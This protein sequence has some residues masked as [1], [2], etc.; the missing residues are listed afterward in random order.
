[1]K[2]SGNVLELIRNG[3]R[4][5]MRE[6]GWDLVSNCERTHLLATSTWINFWSLSA[7]MSDIDIEDSDED[8]RG[9]SQSNNPDSDIHELSVHCLRS[10]RRQIKSEV[11]RSESNPVITQCAWRATMC[12]MLRTLVLS[13]AKTLVS[14]IT[15]FSICTFGGTMALQSA[16]P[17]FMLSLARTPSSDVTYT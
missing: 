4:K 5:G 12:S 11:T 15:N 2:L 6:G 8:S 10:W 1:M 13:N 7:N 17:F 14:L 16:M 9:R 3:E